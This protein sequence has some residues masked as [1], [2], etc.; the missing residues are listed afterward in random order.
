MSEPM[1]AT[2]VKPRRTAEPLLGIFAVLVLGPVGQRLGN[3]SLLF[4][5][6]APIGIST[7]QTPQTSNP[8]R[9]AWQEALDAGR[10]KMQQKDY[11]AA[12][13]LLE[14]AVRLN[15]ANARARRLL[16]EARFAR[17][18][19]QGCRFMDHRDWNHAQRGFERA[20]KYGD[21]AQ[22]RDKLR[23]AK[24]RLS[25]DEGAKLLRSGAYGE[26]AGRYQL[27][28]ELLPDSRE[29]KTGLAEAR[30]RAA[31]QEGTEA[32]SKGLPDKAKDWFRECLA[33]AP[34]DAA[35][36]KQIAQIDVESGRAA[37]FRSTLQAVDSLIDSG[38][39]DRLDGQIKQLAQLEAGAARPDA[40]A[41][42]SLLKDPLLQAI[43]LY[44]HGDLKGALQ[45][46]QPTGR[47]EDRPRLTK[48]RAFLVS[49]RR[50][51][52]LRAWA[53]PLVV[54]YL[55][56]LLASLYLGLRRELAA[57]QEVVTRSAGENEMEAVT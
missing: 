15:P 16:Q 23:I 34:G 12:V 30:Y 38:K 33:Y 53:I 36:L 14:R 41:K 47:A 3:S 28:L 31:Y 21:N 7:A 40:V 24:A 11:D 37:E 26:A 17:S 5:A 45:L 32:L 1:I 46:T 20:L 42:Q 22:L 44:A 50:I 49:R 25:M 8:R 48:F 29:A 2:R 52:I 19:Q 43:F 13:P 35:A 9:S 27:A 18:Y 54:L 4:S 39:W 57:Q 6:G 55:A 51:E 56:F 10:R